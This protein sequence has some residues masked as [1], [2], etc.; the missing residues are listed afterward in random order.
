MTGQRP[1]LGM[2]LGAYAPEFNRA[3]LALIERGVPFYTG[4]GAFSSFANAHNEYLEVAA[5]MGLLGALALGFA[6]L[7]LVRRLVRADVAR[8]SR[9][10]VTAL[11]VST[12]VISSANF[13]FRVGFLAYPLLLV[14][15]WILGSEWSAR[16]A[17]SD[18]ISTED[19]SK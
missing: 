8:S 7:I 1:L 3:K 6:A 14:L 13:P 17:I 4:H 9:A 16:P 15:A 2:G 12:I 11:V 18:A 10:L 5:E 19:P